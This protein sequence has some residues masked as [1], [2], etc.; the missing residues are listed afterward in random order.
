MASRTLT[1]LTTDLR[2][3]ADIEGETDRHPDATL[4]AWLNESCSA[5][6]EEF[7]Q[8]PGAWV[9]RN[10]G[11]T[12]AGTATIALAGAVRVVS[13]QLRD[14]DAYWTLHPVA[15]EEGTEWGNETGAPK[16]YR[17]VNEAS[18][19]S[20]SFAYTPTLRLYP[21]P[22]AVYP[23]VVETVQDFVDLTS[24]SHTFE[25]LLREGVR[26]VVTDAAMQVATK[27]G[28]PALFGMLQARKQELTA[29]IRKA[30]G[31]RGNGPIRRRDT[32]TMRRIEVSDPFYR[33]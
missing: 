1:Q 9:T 12:V 17:L 24:G 3:L 20:P 29:R 13:V 5:Y 6:R 25:P 10:T 4:W 2:A 28:D 33:R 27:D 8:D 31:T 15:A 23:Y 26:W 18:G 19:S 7:G 32:W 21:T 22:D 30:L 16:E 11:N 14:D